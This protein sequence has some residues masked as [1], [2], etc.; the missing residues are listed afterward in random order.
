METDLS[1]AMKRGI[2]VLHLEDDPDFAALTAD[3][4]ERE[5]GRFAVINE[6]TVADARDRFESESFGC[7][8]SDYELPD[9]DGLEFLEA[10][11][12]DDETIPFVLFT[13][14]G[15]EDVASDAFAAGATD[16]LKKGRGTE[17]FT[18]LAKRIENAVESARAKVQR[19]RRLDAI[20]TASE[21]ISILDGNE[22]FVYVNRAYAD[23]YGYDPD[24]IVGRSWELLYPD[25]EIDEIETEVLPRLREE[26][27]WRGRTTGLRAGGGTFV[28]DHTLSLSGNGEMICT[29]RDVTGREARKENLERLETIIRAIGDPVYTVDPDGRFTFV[30]EAYAE[31]TGYD[32]DEMIGSHVSLVVTEESVRKA[33]AVIRR[34]LEEDSSERTDTYEIVIQTRD[35]ERIR[36]EDNLGLLPLKDG[37]FRGNAGTIRN[38]E[39]RKQR[40]LEL[41]QY[42]Q[43]VNAAADMVYVLDDDGYMEFVNDAATDLTGYSREDLIGSHVDLFMEEAAVEEG[44]DL[45]RRL[46]DSDAPESDAYEW[47]LHTADGREVPCES[48]IS[49]IEGEDGIR[50]T[51]GVVRDITERRRRERALE[52]Q[53]E[54][55]EEFA[56]IVSH[57][58]RNPLEVAQMRTEFLQGEFDSP[59]LEHVDS[60]LARMEAI[61]D[62]TLTLARQGWAVAET[63]PVRI[64]GLVRDCWSLVETPTAALSVEDFVVEGDPERLKHVFENLFRNAIEHG[65]PERADDRTITITVAPL[66]DGGGFYVEDDGQGI[67]ADERDRVFEGGYSTTEHG[68]GFGLSI[69]RRVLEAHGWEV[70][71]TESADGGARFEVTG[72]DLLD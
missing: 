29:V 22:E 19:E 67:P 25:D 45:I 16:Y 36:C 12:A 50:G 43:M 38:I 10:V 56:N 57:D 58:L 24:E 66:P 69:V 8:L 42:K 20:E 18:V 65:L 7:I 37:E 6:Q 68:T 41:Q 46:L 11:R 47:T 2:R 3:A 15:S 71:V 53:N 39:A 32:R 51:A 63:E 26:G 34:L 52:R 48:H 21:G 14:Q 31:L 55:L 5:D 60:A 64:D 62:D 35:G 17:Q 23:L 44:R 4:L 1:R 61:I 59:H 40:E 54:Q 70:A 27:V 28:E 30:N 49:L 13:G 72:V 9:G 33:R